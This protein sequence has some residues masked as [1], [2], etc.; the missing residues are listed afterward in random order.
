MKAFRSVLIALA[1]SSLLM[2]SCNNAG[3]PEKLDSFVDKAELNSENYD[4]KD[5]LKSQEQYNRLVKKYANSGK[6]YTEAEKKMAARAMGRYHSLLLK[7]GIKLSAEYLKELGSILPSYLDGLMEGLSESSDEIGKSL[8]GIFN[9]EELEKSIE[10]LG[11]K[12]E[13][14]FGGID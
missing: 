8:E 13:Q 11:E 3:A 2:V 10:S 14:I 5:W 7:N 9:S 1:T 4:E 12:L 6:E